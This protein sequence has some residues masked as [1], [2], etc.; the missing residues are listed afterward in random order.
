MSATE[1]GNARIEK[2]ESMRKGKSGIDEV[3]KDCQEKTIQATLQL[4]D[5]CLESQK[6]MMNSIQSAWPPFLD[7]YMIFYTYVAN[8]LA[9][10]T[11]AL[12]RL[13]NSN[14]VENM[15]IF[16]LSAQEIKKIMQGILRERQ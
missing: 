16:N 3:M 14:V 12:T 10:N 13:L 5:V 11:I 7:L 1:E 15:E 4:N 8:S 9:D 2:Q 6:T